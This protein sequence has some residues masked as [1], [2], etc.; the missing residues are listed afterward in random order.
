VAIP[1]PGVSEPHAELTCADDVVLL[2][3]R[4]SFRRRLVVVVNVDRI[5]A[6]GRSIATPTN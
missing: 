6:V 3:A 5:E 1:H 2:K 4:R